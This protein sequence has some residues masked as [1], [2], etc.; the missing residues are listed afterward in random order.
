MIPVPNL[1]LVLIIAEK[2]SDTIKLGDKELE[3]SEVQRENEK[4]AQNRGTIFAVGGRVEFWEPG[5]LVSFYRAAA[6]PITEDDVEYFSINQVN[7]LCKFVTN[8]KK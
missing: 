3:K 8:V 1:D 6:T 5:D 7:V 2:L 4:K